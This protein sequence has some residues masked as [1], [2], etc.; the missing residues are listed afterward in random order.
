MIPSGT[1]VCTVAQKLDDGTWI[2]RF[3]L[4]QN[5]SYGRIEVRC[6]DVLDFEVGKKYDVCFGIVVEEAKE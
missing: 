2:A 6:G 1:Y 5:D 4:D 3:K